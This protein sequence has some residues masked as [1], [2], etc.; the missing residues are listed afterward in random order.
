M[1]LENRESNSRY[2]PAVILTGI[3]R[4]AA[5]LIPANN[6]PAGAKKDTRAR[7]HGQ[8]HSQDGCFLLE[9]TAC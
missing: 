7:C 5:L 2:L 4:Q 1:R 6:R 3:G 8:P 9:F